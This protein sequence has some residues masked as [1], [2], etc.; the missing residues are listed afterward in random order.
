M[1][2]ASTSGSTRCITHR[3]RKRAVAPSDATA[4]IFVARMQTDGGMVAAADLPSLP[5]LFNQPLR[6]LQK[7]P[8]RPTTSN[9]AI[10]LGSGTTVT[11]AM[12]V[13]EPMGV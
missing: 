9:I 12:I 5:Y 10:V 6:R 4:I 7:R 1:G 8:I 11:S 3:K 2:W 13:G